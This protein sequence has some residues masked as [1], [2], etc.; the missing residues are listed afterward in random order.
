MTLLGQIKD[1]LGPQSLEVPIF[2]LHAVLLPGS[3]MPLR[4]F[5]QRYVE[6]TKT[7]LR[8]SRPFGVCLI[9]EG[10]EVGTPAVPER[11]GCL[12]TILE[13]DMQQLGIFSL[14]TLGTERFAMNRWTV[15]PGGLIRA[16]VSVLPREPETVLPDQ[17][18][19]CARVLELII[20]KLGNDHFHGPFRFD[21]AAWVSY[22]LAETLPLK[23]E[24]RQ[25]LLELDAAAER[26]QV[27]HRFL[28]SQ[29]LAD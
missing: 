17:H 13:W 4:V 29:G 23:L 15:E 26:L 22:R 10:A 5:E 6:M 1:M 27:L 14:R 3:L 12:A 28:T 20:D 11:V 9:Q 18:R 7:C 16:Q 2:P 19:T 8:N 25:K 21:D 24:A